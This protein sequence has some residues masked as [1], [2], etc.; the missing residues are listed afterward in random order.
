LK[1][2]P[3]GAPALALS[4]LVAAF[5]RGRPCPMSKAFNG[6][7]VRNDYG[8]IMFENISNSRM[9]S[10]TQGFESGELWG[11]ND[12]VFRPYERGTARGGVET[13]YVLPMV[14][15][16]QIY[17]RTLTNYVKVNE[18]EFGSDPARYVPPH[19]AAG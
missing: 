1:V 7:A 4:K 13:V 11:M 14:T 15:V 10:F 18:A 3:V 6:V 5:E 16:E 9:G 2:L 17:V 12:Q 8:A 19:P